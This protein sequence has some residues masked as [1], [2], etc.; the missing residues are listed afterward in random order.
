[1]EIIVNGALVRLAAPCTAA[2]FIAARGYQKA[3]IVVERNGAIFPPK[4]WESALLQPGD[5]LEIVTFVGGG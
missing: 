3:R 2:E 5:R 1:M 4:Q